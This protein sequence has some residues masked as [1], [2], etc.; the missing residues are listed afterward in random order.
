MKQLCGFCIDLYSKNERYFCMV[1]LLYKS[2]ALN[3]SILSMKVR[4]ANIEIKR[5]GGHL[6]SI[7]VIMP[8][9]NK[10]EHDDT[11]SVNIPLFGIKTFA[12]GEKDA[13][14]AIE[15]AIKCF[16]FSAEKFGQG[17]ERELEALGWTFVNE[18]ENSSLLTYTIA[19][20]NIVLE[21]IMQTGEQ[22][23]HKLELEEE[24]A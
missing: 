11:L 7:L 9:W 8:K 22:Y 24:L 19:D 15:E 10:V 16:C 6:S 20:S 23:S 21:Q 12:K 2:S 4:E 1:F 14:I 18:D 3:P 13:E 17:I 5:H